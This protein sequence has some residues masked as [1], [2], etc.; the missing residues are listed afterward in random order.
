LT[1]TS[2]TPQFNAINYF[3]CYFPNVGAAFDYN[4]AS[5]VWSTSNTK[6]KNTTLFIKNPDISAMQVV[7]NKASVLTQ[8]SYYS[9]VI[10]TLIT[11]KNKNTISNS[12]NV[13]FSPISINLGSI[14]PSLSIGVLF[15]KS[16]EFDLSAV[17]AVGS[18]NAIL[19]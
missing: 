15:G 11:L 13:L 14:S 6:V 8:Q 16:I 3:T 12:V 18:S 19:Y 1:A 9:L 5:T 4:I 2:T 7:S 10:T 17:A